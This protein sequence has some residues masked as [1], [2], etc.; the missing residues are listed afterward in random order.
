MSDT[1]NPPKQQPDEA[2]AA[3]TPSPSF[4]LTDLL[5]PTL[6]HNDAKKRTMADKPTMDVMKDKD[7]V[8]L[9]FSAA[10]CPPCQTFSPLLKDFYK[11]AAGPEKLEIVYISSDKTI[12]EFEQYFGNM[13]WWSLPVTDSAAIKNS[14][15]QACNVQ[16]I[17]TLIVLDATTGH[18]ITDQARGQ[19]TNVTKTPEAVQELVATWKATEA[20]PLSQARI[21]GDGPQSFVGMILQT[22]LKNPAILIGLVYAGKVCM[23]VFFGESH[24]CGGRTSLLGSN[25]DAK[26]KKKKKEEHD[27][28]VWARVICIFLSCDQSIDGAF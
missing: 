23:T 24:C 6:I 13:P 19:I 28:S 16:G 12:P 9:Y 7:L 14:L 18:Y 8:L 27:V 22:V 15:A 20:V 2:A 5:G 10:W 25:M 21:G 17:P 4:R 1:T 3:A 11:L 26:K